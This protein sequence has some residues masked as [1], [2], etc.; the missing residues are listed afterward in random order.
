MKHCFLAAFCL[1]G[2]LMAQTPERRLEELLLLPEPVV[3]RSALS[4][5]PEGAELTV[6]TPA[7]ELTDVPG[8]MA[9]SA[10]DF[11]KLGL[12][13]ETFAERAKKVADKRLA[14]LKPEIIKDAA[15]KAQYAVY[16]SE[17]PLIASLL[18]APSLPAIFEKL[19]GAE[20]WVAL[21]DRHSLF[22]F[23]AKP[24]SLEEFAPDLADRFRTDPRAASPEIFAIKKG[25]VPKVV[26]SF[27]E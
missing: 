18:I 24:E 7:K 14:A 19:F 22:V 17:Q 2:G 4:I 23:P 27:V 1:L 3:M 15:G 25:G 9:Y 12:S 21:P 11:K 20:I 6:L 26:G 5:V 13:V 10:E 16:R 8:I